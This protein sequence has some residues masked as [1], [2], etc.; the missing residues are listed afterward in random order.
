MNAHR[1]ATTFAVVVEATH[2]PPPTDITKVATLYHEELEVYQLSLQL[3]AC[4][5]ALS[6]HLPRG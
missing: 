2:A 5:G 6:E 4:A 3:V 1:V